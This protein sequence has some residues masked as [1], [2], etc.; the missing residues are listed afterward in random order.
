[1]MCRTCVHYLL[2]VSLVLV[3]TLSVGLIS[4]ETPIAYADGFIDFESG[5]DSQPIQS[6]IPGLQFT[7]TEGYDWVYADWRTG[8][9]N[10]PYPDGEYYSNGNFFAWLGPNQGAGRIDFTESGATYLQVWVSSAFGLT[11]DAYDASGTLIDTESVAANLDTGQMARLRVEAPPGQT[12]SYVIFH[13]TGNYWLIDDLSTDASGVPATRPPIVLIPGLMGS[14]LNMY[15]TQDQEET[16]VWPPLY[17]PSQHAINLENIAQFDLASLYLAENGSDPADAHNFV[18]SNA[19]LDYFY[20]RLLGQQ[21][22]EQHHYDALVQYLS[23]AGFS[24]YQYHYD[25]RLDVRTPLHGRGHDQE[26][27]TLDEFIDWVLQ[28]SGAQ[29]VNIVAHSLGGLVT[30]A[31]VSASPENAAKVEQAIILG[32][33]YLGAPETMLAFRAGHRWPGQW[34]HQI[35]LISSKLRRFAQN[36]PAL[37]QILPSQRYLNVAGGGWF[38]YNGQEYNWSETEGFLQEHHNS[39]LV[40]V[41]EDLHGT[42]DYWDAIT[43]DVAF[44]FIV[45]TGVEGTVGGVREETQPWWKGGDTWDIIPTNGDGTVPLVSASLEGNGYDYRSDVPIW[46]ADGVNHGDLTRQDYILDFIVAMLATPP[47]TQ[48]LRRAHRTA[49]SASHSAAP[50]YLGNDHPNAPDYRITAPPTPPEMSQTPF[51]LDGAQVSVFQAAALHIYDSSG[52]HTGPTDDE[53]IETEIPGSTYT[54]VDNAIFATVPAGA[55][56]EIQVEPDGDQE[57]DLRVR[58]VEGLTT[59]FIQHTL[60]YASTQVGASG[61]ASL[62]YDPDLPADSSLLSL[63]FDSDGSV[64]AYVEPTGE[65]GPEDSHDLTAPST[66]IYLEGETD[67]DGWYTGIVRITLVATD[68]QSGVA[69]IEYTIDEGQTIQEYQEPFQVVAEQTPFVFAQAIDRA[70]NRETPV[71]AVHLRPTA[72]HIYL[73]IV[74]CNYTSGPTGVTNGDFESGSTDWVEYSTHGW[75]LIVTSCPGSITPHSGSWITWLGGDHDEISYIQQQVIVPFNSPYLAYWHWIASEDYCG[76]DFGSV[77]INGSTIVDVYNLC[78]S[79]N[80]EGWVKHV[81]NLSTY[82]G[83]SVSLQIRAETD[84][85]LNSNLFIDDV[86]FQSSMSSVQS[87]P[88]LVNV[89]NINIMPKSSEITPRGVDEDVTTSESLFH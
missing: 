17:D 76:Y 47:D 33:P 32:T 68:D 42:V 52:H 1:M 2:A 30:R 75:D 54:T 4:Y 28:D 87:R 14:Q 60:V 61:M 88:T 50:L 67:T 49:H 45:G 5:V 80:T 86:S 20:I 35:P 55:T 31:Y 57:F 21:L 51:P 13:D 48:A 8:E 59:Q 37:Y 46:Y 78:E 53:G 24:V 12:I 58:D 82:A 66:I 18:F 27:E 44:R 65:L 70:G 43:G 36:A 15:D 16:I 64:D 74:L 79:E 26:R 85:S 81:V 19:V 63:D 25:W 7:T 38:W 56:Y 62:T 3:S 39:S 41:A 11:A 83:Q 34:P 10:G 9:Y 22:G 40:D 73:P 6:L 84:S 23:D 69:A 71:A 77:I 29:Q 72:H 89:G